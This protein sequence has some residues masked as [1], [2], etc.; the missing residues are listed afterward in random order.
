MS[1]AADYLT[2]AQVAATCQIHRDHVVQL[3]HRGDLRGVW[4]GRAL[5]IPREA[6]EEF[7]SQGGIRPEPRVQIEEFSCAYT[8]KRKRR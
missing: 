4:F 7:V 1:Q 6:L 2:T 3:V 5:R 8:G